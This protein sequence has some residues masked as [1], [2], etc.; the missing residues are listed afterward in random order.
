MYRV[1]PVPAGGFCPLTASAIVCIAPTL[2]NRYAG[3]TGKT[4]NFFGPMRSSS[5]RGE[6][7]SM[8]QNPRP[9]VEITRS[10][11]RVWIVSHETGA[12]GKLF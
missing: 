3:R 6:M 5:R 7:S 8:I 1:I 11:Y 4:A 10:S 12:C 2:R 9:Y